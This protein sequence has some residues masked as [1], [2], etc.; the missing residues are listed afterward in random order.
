MYVYI[1]TGFPPLS[2]QP[3]IKA[4][5]LAFP[6]GWGW[7][8]VISGSVW[9]WGSFLLCRLSSPSG[10]GWRLWFS[11]HP[12]N[13]SQLGLANNLRSRW[14]LP[15]FPSF[16]LLFSYLFHLSDHPWLKICT[17]MFYPV[18]LIAVSE[19]ADPN[20]LAFHLKNSSIITYFLN[21]CRLFY[22][23]HKPK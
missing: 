20:N 14:L 15:S 4:T 10:L 6:W 11:F 17:F 13:R 5:S 1:W 23:M 12:T 19:R 8:G 18:F 7:V 22:H 9:P 2:A 21:T 3:S 16:L